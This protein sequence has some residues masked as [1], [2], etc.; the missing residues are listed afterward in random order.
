MNRTLVA[1][2]T[3]LH[4][5]PTEKAARNL[6]NEGVERTQ[7]YVTGNSGIDAVLHVK[8]GLE[9]GTLRGAGRPQLDPAKNRILGTAHR[10]DSFGHGFA[11]I[12]VAI[13]RH[14][15]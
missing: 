6:E 3:N 1:R 5:A 12:C 2:M 9:N 8:A 11:N 15:T 4:F 10:R 14:T 13:D 7:I